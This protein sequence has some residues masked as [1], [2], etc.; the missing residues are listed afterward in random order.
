MNPYD[1]SSSAPVRR[2]GP[3][4]ADEC[5]RRLGNKLLLWGACEIILL[6]MLPQFCFEW[7]LMIGRMWVLYD[8]GALLFQGRNHQRR[9]D[10]ASE[11]FPDDVVQADFA[12][13]PAAPPVVASAKQCRLGQ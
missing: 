11:A 6:L 9:L 7:P 3:L 5:Y 2:R 10:D 1:P 12:D 8:I 13:E 4:F